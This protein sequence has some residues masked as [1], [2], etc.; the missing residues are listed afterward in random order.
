MDFYKNTRNLNN[1]RI[2]LLIAFLILFFYH[3]YNLIFY[4]KTNYW[5]LLGSLLSAFT[6]ISQ[7]IIHKQKSNKD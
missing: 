6:M 2:I 3:I 5:G 7:I 1:F 4:K